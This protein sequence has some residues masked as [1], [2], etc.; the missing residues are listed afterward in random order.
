MSPGA[1]A[2]AVVGG[3]PA[4][5]VIGSAPVTVSSSAVRVA[6]L[7]A[8]VVHGISATLVAPPPGPRQPFS[9]FE[10]EVAVDTTPLTYEGDSAQV[11]AVA[12]FSDGTR[13]QLDPSMGLVVSPAAAAGSITIEDGG[14]HVVVPFMASSAAGDLL[15]ADWV[16]SGC[17][18]DGSDALIA[19]GR[20]FVNVSLPAALSATVRVEGGVPGGPPASPPFLVPAGGSAAAA[21]LATNATIVVE[22]VYADRTVD[23]TADPRTEFDLTAV[24]GMLVVDKA[25]REVRALRN[26]RP[27][28]GD[29]VV[30][31]GHEG[32]VARVTVEVAVFRALAARATPYPRYPGSEAVPVDTLYLIAGSS[33]PQHEEAELHAAMHL[34]NGHSLDLARG[35]WRTAVGGGGA[36]AD[37]DVR[38]VAPATAAVVVTRAV[39]DGAFTAAFAFSGQS[40]TLALSASAAPVHVTGIDSVA[41]VVVAQSGKTK[42]RLGSKRALRGA[43]GAAPAHTQVSVTLSNGRRLAKLFDG[44]GAGE[45]YVPGLVA[46]TT[47]TPSAVLVGATS[48]TVVLL[49]N[50][51]SSV[52][53]T[54]H[55]AAGQ[56]AGAAATLSRGAAFAVN[57]DPTRGGDVD[58]GNADGQP[59][60]PRKVGEVFEVPLRVNT[61][62]KYLGAFDVFVTFDPAVLSLGTPDPK[63]ACGACWQGCTHAR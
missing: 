46:F 16:S 61:G 43:K 5:P 38:G 54:A 55:V 51:P 63:F 57:L 20:A 59:L 14:D 52:T 28:T 53:V 37:I 47:D 34:T 49:D 8:R 44:D 13:M 45:P 6:G 17:G 22:L 32:V 21:G 11:V 27:G 35:S 58:L 62:S 39:G 50:S 4:A 48:G 2:V 42:T 33:P 15:T 18:A 19:T 3:A 25:S 30:R 7:H 26:A 24:A 12:T 29:I 40:A 31:F 23:A 9:P 56:E 36:G 1:A 10:V 41:A 60:L